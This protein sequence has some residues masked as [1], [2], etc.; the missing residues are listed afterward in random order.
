MAP[1]MKGSHLI[2]QAKVILRKKH[3]LSRRGTEKKQT[4]CHLPPWH[5]GNDPLAYNLYRFFTLEIDRALIRIFIEKQSS[6]GR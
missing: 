5:T 3:G 1:S 2:V 4:Q 6:Y